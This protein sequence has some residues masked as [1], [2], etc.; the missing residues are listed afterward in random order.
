MNNCVSRVFDKNRKHPFSIPLN[1]NQV[2][3]TFIFPNISVDI[4]MINA[5]LK[6]LY[7]KTELES[8]IFFFLNV[9]YY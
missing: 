1:L 6:P 3:S 9:F 4:F 7:S 2:F 5:R 8:P